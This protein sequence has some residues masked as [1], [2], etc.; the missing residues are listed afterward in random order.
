MAQRRLFEARE[1]TEDLSRRAAEAARPT[2]R[3]SS[4]PPAWRP[5]CS[6]SRR[7]RPNS[8]RGRPRSPPSSTRRAARRPI[9]ARPSSPAKRSSTPTCDARRPADR[10]PDGRRRGFGA[11]DQ[12]D[13]HE[14]R[15]RLRARALESIRALVAEL[16]VARA[17]AESDLAHLATSCARHGAGDARRRAGGSRRARARGRLDARRADHLRR[18]ARRGPDDATDGDAPAPSETRCSKRRA[19]GPQRRRSHRPAARARSIGSAR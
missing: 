18:R 11:A 5:K 12:T 8:R 7:R 19:A 4:A 16:D 1:A 9:C 2:P 14:S 17:T 15:S 6:V 10:C 3:W 13:E